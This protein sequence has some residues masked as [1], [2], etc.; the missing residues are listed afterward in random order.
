MFSEVVNVVKHLNEFPSDSLSSVLSN[1]FHF[2]AY[3]QEVQRLLLG[4]VR[5]NGLPL[6]NN[7]KA[8]VKLSHPRALKNSEK[9]ELWDYD[10]HKDSLSMCSITREE[11]R[12]IARLP[13]VPVFVPQLKDWY[14][15]RSEFFSE[16]VS[17]WRLNS[18]GV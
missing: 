17:S 4:A 18:D 2:D 8:E 13:Y 6:E 3:D 11:L 10:V 9:T 7:S 5:R 14:D 16:E 15:R 12:P 1:V